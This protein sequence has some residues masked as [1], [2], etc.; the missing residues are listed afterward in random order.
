MKSV[1]W[2]I[3]LSQFFSYTYTFLKNPGLPDKSMSISQ[4][5]DKEF[6]GKICNECGIV[7]LQGMR[8][9]HCDDCNVCIIGKFNNH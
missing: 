2:A 6:K 1:G 8:I 4:Y 5:K 3:Y 9:M 7:V